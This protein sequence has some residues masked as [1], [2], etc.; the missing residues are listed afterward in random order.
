MKNL[1]S[2]VLAAAL[3]LASMTIASAKSYNVVLSAPTAAGAAQ[4][5]AGSYK[6]DV[7]THYATFTN[8]E[9]KKSVMVLYRLNSTPTTYDRTAV[10]LKSDGSAQRIESIELENS[11]SKLEF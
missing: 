5:P 4:L 10:D 9:N 1:K 8:L 3:G 2:I 11:G 7:T 6:I